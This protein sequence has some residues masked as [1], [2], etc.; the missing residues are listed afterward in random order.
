MTSFSLTD[1]R[2]KRAAMTQG[3]YEWDDRKD[4]IRVVGGDSVFDGAPT[5]HCNSSL[6]CSADDATGIV[7][8]H[9]AAD[10][11]IEIAEAA[12]EWKTAPQYRER[13]ARMRLLEAIAKVTP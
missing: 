5:G 3:E 13:S 1:L 2:S 6:M 11:L 8:T 10:L 7:A 12:L 9:N 4:L